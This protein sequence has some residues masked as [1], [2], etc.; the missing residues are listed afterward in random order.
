MGSSIGIEMDGDDELKRHSF[1]SHLQSLPYF[2][3]NMTMD[4]LD[5]KSYPEYD[6]MTPG[7]MTQSDI[8]CHSSVTHLL[9]VLPF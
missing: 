8:N 3:E 2:G 7:E 1:V 9:P 6:T 4:E 5:A